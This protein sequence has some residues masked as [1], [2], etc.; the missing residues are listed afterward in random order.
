MATQRELLL[1]GLVDG[2]KS[3]NLLICEV[4][5][6]LGV[7]AN[8]VR[9]RLNE[10]VKERRVR[11]EDISGEIHAVL[12]ADNRPPDDTDLLDIE[13]QLRIAKDQ[14]GALQKKVKALHR[15][16]DA[17]MRIVD[18]INDCAAVFDPVAPPKLHTLK[19]GLISETSVLH[20]GDTHIDELVDVRDTGGLAE[21]NLEIATTRAQSLVEKMIDIK[22]N[23]LLGYSLDDLVVF[24]LGDI[25]STNIHG[26]MDNTGACPVDALFHAAYLYAQMLL[27]FARAYRSVR[28][29]CVPGNHGRVTE[30]VR[31]KQPYNN[32]DYVLSQFVAVMMQNQPN[33]SFEIPRSL[34][35]VEE[36][37]GWNWLVAHGSFARSWQGVPWYGIVRSLKNI[38]DLLDSAHTVQRRQKLVDDEADLLEEM[39]GIREDMWKV[40]GIK[41]DYCA[42]GHFHTSGTLDIGT[43]EVFMNGSMIGATDYSIQ[44]MQAG[45]AP[46]HWYHGMNNKHGVT[47]RYNLD[48]DRV[49]DNMQ[50]RYKVGGE[51]LLVNELEK[52]DAR[53]AQ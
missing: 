45:N 43:G 47:W 4:V 48:L 29:I 35:V 9:R 6:E 17:V 36:I 32:W 27:D 1:N 37:E 30:E 46:R 41:F 40:H 52:L 8:S 20:L 23:R 49:P 28:V 19:Q 15:E 18:A 50:P 33:I 7:D 39:D 21:Y 16:D 42:L 10:L 5:D 38:R 12:L 31:F 14:N 2:M 11:Y 34:W 44:R 26:I 24:S 13:R 25:V 3:R 22:E 53:T 51:G